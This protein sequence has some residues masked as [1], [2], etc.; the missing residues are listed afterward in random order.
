MHRL[1]KSF[2]LDYDTL[3][4]VSDVLQ[5]VEFEVVLLAKL[6]SVRQAGTNFVI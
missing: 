3:K 5:L 1:T 6:V 4:R 2:E